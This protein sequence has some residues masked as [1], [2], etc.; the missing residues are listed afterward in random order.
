ME[1]FAEENPKRNEKKAFW[2]GL[3]TILILILIVG[4]TIFFLRGCSGDQKEIKEVKGDQTEP[5]MTPAAATPT[6]SP[7]AVAGEKTGGSPTPT[8]Q[9]ETYTI[10]SGD[11]LYEIGQKFKVDWHKIAEANGID[12]SGA[13]KVGKQIIIP[14]Q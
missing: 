12:N 14:A 6:V 5:A 3:A 4:L 9:G 10:E 13:L 11:T 8:V 1:E 2:V 7:A